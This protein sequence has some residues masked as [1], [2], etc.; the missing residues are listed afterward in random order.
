MVGTKRQGDKGEWEKVESGRRTLTKWNQCKD[1]D[2]TIAAS[3]QKF[4]A[5]GFF[6]LCYVFNYVFNATE[7]PVHL[8]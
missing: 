3:H 7:L 5:H 4:D 2:S 8:H 6:M 1:D